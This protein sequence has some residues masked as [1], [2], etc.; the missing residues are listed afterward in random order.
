MSVIFSP[1]GDELR[2]TL[3]CAL[4]EPSVALKRG[5]NIALAAALR[6]IARRLSIAFCALRSIVIVSSIPGPPILKR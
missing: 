3:S 2:L 5:P 6:S 4:T 1:L